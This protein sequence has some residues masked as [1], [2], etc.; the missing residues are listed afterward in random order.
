MVVSYAPDD[1][2]RYYDDLLQGRYDCLDRIVVRAYFELGGRGAGMRYWWRQLHDGSEGNLDE[3]H[4]RRMAGRFARRVRAYAEAHDILVIDCDT[5]EQKHPLAE[6][7]IPEDPN[8]TGVFLILVSRGKAP[9]WKVRRKKGPHLE[10]K[11]EYVKHYHFQIIDPEWGHLSIRMSGHPPFPALVML[12]G[13][14][15]VER[16]AAKQGIVV[17]KQGNCFTGYS[18]AAAFQAIADTLNSAESIGRL[19]RVCDRWIYSACLCFGLSTQDQ[20]RSGF[21]YRYSAYQLEYSRNLIF[22]RGH[23]M[24]QVFRR[25]IE[26]TYGP[27]DVRTLKTIFGRKVRPRTRKEGKPQPRMEATV[28][29]PTYDLQVFRLQFGNLVLKMYTKGE[30]VLRIE[31]VA[32]DS[33]ELRCGKALQN[34]PRMVAALRGMVDR[35]LNL[36]Q[37]AH[38]AFLDE[39]ALDELPQP[40]LRGKQRLAGVDVNK[41]RMRAVMEAVMALAPKPGGFSIEQLAQRVREMAGYPAEA[42]GVRQAAYDLKKLRGKEMVERVEGTRRYTATLPGFATMCALVI[43]REKVIKPVMA[44]A[45]RPKRGRPPKQ[46]SAMDV[47]YENLRRELWSALETLGLAA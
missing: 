21:R 13:H 43:I 17:E 41:P 7:H 26:L 42:Y 45:A 23:I 44:G 4:L 39:G 35:F 12:N 3:A 24:E 40:T 27:L 32:H 29:R 47:H 16:Q 33:K 5:D 18:E 2:S 8:F 28:E 46:P 19:A 6:S 9:V 10:S 25:L 34:A 37:Y 15:W 14:E 20:E 30:R 22:E 1:L 38:Q 11:L 36:A 31:A